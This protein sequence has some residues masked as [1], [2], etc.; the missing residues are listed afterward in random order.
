M[1]THWK[2]NAFVILT[3]CILIFL[4]L[5]IFFCLP[6]NDSLNT[7]TSTSK[8]PH[9]NNHLN[10]TTIT[11]A[12]TTTSNNPLTTHT[13]SSINTSNNRNN[14]DERDDGGE[15]SDRSEGRLFD[16]TEITTYT[17]HTFEGDDDWIIEDGEL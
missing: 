13:T 1:T 5:I 17:N 2:Q 7:T 14:D 12:A 16:I 10:W 8:S 3:T 11:T 9:Q 4:G 15:N 6:V